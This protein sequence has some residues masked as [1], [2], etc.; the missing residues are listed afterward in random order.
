MAN[1]SNIYDISLPLFNGM[2]SYRPEWKNDITLV[3]STANRDPSTVYQ[4]N[5]F[6]HTGTYIETSQHKLDNKILL[7]DFSL[8]SFH[9]ECYVVIVDRLVENQVTLTDFLET[10]ACLGESI[11]RGAKLIIGTGYGEN[12]R[13]SDYLLCAPSFEP[14]LTDRLIEMKLSLLGVDTPI[15]DN[16]SSPYLPVTKLFEANNQLLLLAPLLLD[17]KEIKTGKYMLSCFPSFKSEV[18]SSLTRGILVR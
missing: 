16:Q 13:R 17:K 12:H 3:S 8:R 5:V 1:D 14:L 4:F 10:E 11:P 2:W 15:L 7:S 9:G 18:S 6:S